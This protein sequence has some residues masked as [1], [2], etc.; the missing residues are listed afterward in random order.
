VS[1]SVIAQELHIVESELQR[2]ARSL[3]A[4]AEDIARRREAVAPARRTSLRP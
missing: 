2:L 3:E 1:D 4:T